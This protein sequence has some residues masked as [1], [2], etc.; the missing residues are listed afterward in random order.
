LK[1]SFIVGEPDTEYGEK[2]NSQEKKYQGGGKK[3]DI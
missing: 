1:A 3:I 2:R